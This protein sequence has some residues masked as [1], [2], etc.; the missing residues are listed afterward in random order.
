MKK[1]FCHAVTQCLL[2]RLE[3]PGPW[4]GK[5][6]SFWRQ[7]PKTTDGVPGNRRAGDCAAFHQGAYGMGR[8][9]DEG[10]VVQ[11]FQVLLMPQ[12]A[13]AGP[14]GKKIQIHKMIRLS[15]EQTVQYSH[16]DKAS[17]GMTHATLL[18]L[19]FK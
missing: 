5:G 16:C 6:G 8:G 18:T 15:G 9:S 14:A 3:K 17:T 19:N 1:V 10:L 4:G 2:Q 7:V 13:R 12:S 11:F